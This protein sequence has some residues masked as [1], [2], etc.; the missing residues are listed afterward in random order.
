[1]EITCKIIKVLEPSRFQSKKDGSEIVKNTFVGETQGQYPKTIAF[2]VM[3]E[4]R[5]KQMNIAVGGQYN[6]SFD[7]ESREWND[8][9]FT[10]CSAWRAVRVDGAQVQAQTQAPAQKP[11]PAPPSPFPTGDANGQQGNAD[12]LPF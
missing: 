8:K 5:F 11:Q 3:G 4:D 10:E 12:D 6:V 2:S 9:W 1:M 7:V